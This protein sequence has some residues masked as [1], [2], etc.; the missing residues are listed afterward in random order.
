MSAHLGLKRYRP[1]CGSLLETPSPRRPLRLA[2]LL[3]RSTEYL[4][5]KGVPSPRVDAE[6]LLAHALGLTRVQLYTEHDR[7]LREAELERVRELVRRRGRREP[8]AYVLGEWGFRRLT[9]AV[10]RRALVPR[11]E[12]EVVV[13]RCL[14]LLDGET[15]P[16]VLDVGVGSG[17]I[18]LAIA[19]EHPPA[20]VVGVDTS[21][22]A[23]ALAREN[24]D[25]LRLGVELREGGFETAA[26]GWDLVVANPPYV[27]PEEYET[28]QPEVRQWEPRAAL[29]GEGLHVEVA[30]VARTRW[31]VLEVGDGQAPEVAEALAELG[32]ADVRI[33]RDLAERERVVEG[34]QT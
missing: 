11:P 24:A 5:D 4:R 26:E 29:V 1:T 6:H 12:T 30:R 34:R 27:S 28:L 8:L 18:A 13:E 17:A 25:R 19:D 32:Y 31:L 2:E 14:R 33:S 23:L 15:E 7:P 16:R 3:R 22:D 9:I 20:R 10:D 21:P